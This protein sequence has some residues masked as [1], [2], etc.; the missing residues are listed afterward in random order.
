LDENEE[1]LIK[2]M[3]HQ[4]ERKVVLARMLIKAQGEM[5]MRESE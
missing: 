5:A 4:E 3:N 1:K 2:P